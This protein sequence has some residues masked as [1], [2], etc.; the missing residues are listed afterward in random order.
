MNT[1]KAN[2]T[3]PVQSE[4]TRAERTFSPVAQFRWYHRNTLDHNGRLQQA[5]QSR[6]TDDVEWRDVPH[7]YE[8]TK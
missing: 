4:A 1:N 8:P 3:A 5:H 7:F 6:E 2:Q